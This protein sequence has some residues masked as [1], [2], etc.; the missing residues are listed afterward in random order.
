VCVKYYDNSKEIP[1]P[2]TI[3][4]NLKTLIIFDDVML[5]KE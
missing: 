2:A 4:P 5:E 1:D 3:D